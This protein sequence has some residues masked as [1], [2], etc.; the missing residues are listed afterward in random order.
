[1]PTFGA[2]QCTRAQPLLSKPRVFGRPARHRHRH[3]HRDRHRVTH[4]APMLE[5]GPLN[6]KLT[7]PAVQFL[8]RPA[9]HDRGNRGGMGQ[10]MQPERQHAIAFPINCRSRCRSLREPPRRLASIAK[11]IHPR[12][13][14]PPI[15][16]RCSMEDARRH[17]H[18]TD[19]Q[20]SRQHRGGASRSSLVA[21][22]SD[23]PG[24]RAA[25]GSEVLRPTP[26]PAG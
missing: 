6:Q 11:S 24:H 16:P 10:R 13:E 19:S 23:L 4:L 8:L 26:H 18:D 1:M 3:R 7:R 21:S 17:L 20:E 25:F 9:G 15:A 5:C 14:I 2:R 22:S 12:G